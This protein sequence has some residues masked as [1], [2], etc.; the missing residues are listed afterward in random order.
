MMSL[1]LQIALPILL[2]ACSPTLDLTLSQV[3][4]TLYA[5]VRTDRTYVANEKGHLIWI[6]EDG[7]TP[8]VVMVDFGKEKTYRGLFSFPLNSWYFIPESETVLAHWVP[9]IGGLG[10]TTEFGRV[11]VILRL[12]SLFVQRRFPY[13]MSASKK[14]ENTIR[15]QRFQQGSWSWLVWVWRVVGLLILVAF[16]T[17]FFVS[18]WRSRRSFKRTRR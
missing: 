16:T 8:R 9:G 13:E 11:V 2:L 12:N 3:G 10:A 5:E 18:V 4:S 17:A 1:L 6:P 15:Q 7:R 14:D